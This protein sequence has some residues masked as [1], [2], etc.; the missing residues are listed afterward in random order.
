[1]FKLQGDVESGTQ[2]SIAIG[3]RGGSYETIVPNSAVRSDNNG[4]FVL[5]VVAKN[6]PLG[7]RYI[8]QRIDVKVL[9]SDDVNTAVS[10]GLTTSDFVITTSTKPIEP[11]MQVRLPD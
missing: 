11:G 7:N 9:A 2:L 8:A 1:F 5:A 6:G 10:G 3:E 4:S